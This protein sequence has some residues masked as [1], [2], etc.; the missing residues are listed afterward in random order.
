M[1]NYIYKVGVKVIYTS[2]DIGSHS[3]KIVVSSKS[4]GKFH[5]LASTK[6]KSKGIKK[7]IIKDYALALESIKEAIGEINKDLGI[8]IKEVL[9]SFPMF[10]ATSS[11]ETGEINVN[12]EIKGTHIKEVI[13]KTVHENI[14]SNLEVLYLEPIV[15]ETDTG[16]QVVDPKGLTSSTLEVRCAVSTV[17][18]DFLYE[19][20]ELLHEAGLEV[21]D[22]VYGIVGDY[23]E[24]GNTETDSKFGALI[25]LGYGKT[26]IGIFNKGILLKGS[27]LPIGSSKID[28]DI[29]YIYKIDRKFA[30]SLKENFAVASSNYAD[31]NDVMEVVKINQL[32]IS[33]IVEARLLEII[34][35]VKNEINNLTNR[36]IGYIII[37]GGITN[38]VG[39]PYLLEDEFPEIDKIVANLIPIGA[40]SNVY[41][42]GLGFIKYF[43]Y[44][45]KFRDI[46]YSMLSEESKKELTAKKKD[47]NKARETLFSKLEAYSESN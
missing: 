38:L 47:A 27:T 1:Y 3:I 14:D 25:N 12:G 11:I 39:F 40:R 16:V 44:K 31:S 9:L 18:K 17:E 30:T 7:G 20:L 33:Q 4:N 19:Y 13:N 36:K 43:D 37:T 42:T 24:L 15:F 10:K 41:S 21:I 22:V 2:I 8:E 34:K 26:E 28:K 35:S 45:M 29:S 6:V 5:I 32:E 46:R 23:E